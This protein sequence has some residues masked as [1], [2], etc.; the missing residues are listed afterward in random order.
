MIFFSF[1]ACVH[2]PEVFQ[3]RE[4]RDLH[5]RRRGKGGGEGGGEKG[6]LYNFLLSI[7]QY[8][9]PGHCIVI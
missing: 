4:E 7:E 5:I 9:K 2:S 1:L 8:N 6:R 3:D